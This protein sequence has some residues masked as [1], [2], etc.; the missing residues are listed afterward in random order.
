Q[1]AF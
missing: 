1:K